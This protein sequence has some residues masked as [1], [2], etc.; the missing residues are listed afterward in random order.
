MQAEAKFFN[1]VSSRGIDVTV[2]VQPALQ[3]LLILVPEDGL[4]QIPF[5]EVAIT[6]RD[7]ELMMLS[8]GQPRRILEIRDD[9]FAKS[10][11][12]AQKSKAT[13]WY[14]NL[15]QT[16]WKGYLSFAAV[17][18][19]FIGLVY[20]FAVPFIAEKAVV[21]IP[22]SFDKKIGIQAYDQ[23]TAAEKADTA[24]GRL[25]TNYY[26][27]FNPADH[28]RYTLTVIRTDEMNA[29][30]LPDGHIVVYSG[31]LKKIHTSAELAGLLAHETSH[32]T[33][34]HSM[35]ILCKSLAGYMVVSLML[36]DVNGIMAAI[37]QNANSLQNLN[38]SRGFE[39]E[40]DIS[41]FEMLRK[42]KIDPR[43]MITLF[44]ILKK[45]ETLH[46]PGFLS[47]HPVTQ[48]RIDYLQAKIKK[49]PYPLIENQSL[50]NAFDA[51]KKEVDSEQE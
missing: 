19:V 6:H 9:D 44:E 50:N 18:V 8:F 21:L 38:Y 46:V 40:A 32:L 4:L 23:L 25:L 24:A 31:I 42:E 39:K 48:D 51:L 37:A 14:H 47:T 30:A 5:N 35:K 27:L 33:H 28:L 13:L 43:G 16:G 26:S 34:R 45:Q 12:A 20:F 1:G 41:G 3:Q 22:T 2:T 7:R 11:L 15:L 17:V 29:F 10:Y 49:E 36:N